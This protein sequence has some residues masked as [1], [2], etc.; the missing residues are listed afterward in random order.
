MQ[1]PQPMQMP[2][3]PSAPAVG[4]GYPPAGTTNYP[5]GPGGYPAA[6]SGYPPSSG[7]YP[8]SSGGYPPSSGGY[9]PSSG[10]Y[11]SASGGFPPSNN[12]GQAPSSYHPAPGAPSHTSGVYG[13]PNA[14]GPHGGFSYTQ[15]SSHQMNQG[16]YKPA[17]VL[18]YLRSVCLLFSGV[19]FLLNAIFIK[20]IFLRLLIT[21]Q[22]H[23][24]AKIV[25]LNLNIK[26]LYDCQFRNIYI[27]PWCS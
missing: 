5:P 17:K 9:P 25:I 23:F 24:F 15:H 12:Q 27:L 21:F 16:S 1:M 14:H 8:P 7:G 26:I 3:Y 19:T 2:T 20:G 22:I 18:I 6:A 13:G 11:P 4:G 10:G